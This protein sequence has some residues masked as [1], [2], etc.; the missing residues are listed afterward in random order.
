MGCT[1]H[2]CPG[3]IRTRR[4]GGPVRLDEKEEVSGTGNGNRRRLPTGQGMLQVG[5]RHR[6]FIQAPL[7]GA[8]T[9]KMSSTGV[10]SSMVTRL[11]KRCGRRT[12]P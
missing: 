5:G 7:G 11:A 6:H 2:R 3:P 8:R 1:I 4:G 10:T 9:R 12:P